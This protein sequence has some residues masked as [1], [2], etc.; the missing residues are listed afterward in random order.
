MRF[1]KATISFVLVLNAKGGKLKTKTTGSTI[2]CEFFKKLSEG[3]KFAKGI[4]GFLSKS[5]YCKK[6]LSCG[7]RNLIMGKGGSFWLF[8]KTSLEKYFDLPKQSVLTLR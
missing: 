7:R 2:T 4:L 8:V 6:L 3:E 5:S 1:L